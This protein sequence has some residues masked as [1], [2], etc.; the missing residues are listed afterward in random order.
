MKK[1]KVFFFLLLVI[2]I[3]SLPKDVDAAGL[4]NKNYCLS[5]KRYYQV[6]WDPQ[7]STAVTLDKI[8]ETAINNGFV[9]Y[10]PGTTDLTPYK[11]NVVQ[12]ADNCYIDSYGS[13]QT[14]PTTAEDKKYE[15]N[16]VLALNEEG[17]NYKNIIMELNLSNGLINIKIK[18]IFNGT[19]KIR[20]A[21]TEQ[22][23]NL[24]GR[25]ATEL[26]NFLTKEGDYYVLRNV[27]PSTVIC[28][29]NG[30]CSIDTNK[31]YFEY[32]I[33]D[34]SSPCNNT[35]I[36]GIDLVVNTADSVDIDNP[37]LT[38][39]DPSNSYG[40]KTVED[41]IQYLIDNKIIYS[42]DPAYLQTLITTLKQS[43]A[44]ICYQDKITYSQYQTL[45][46]DIQKA[47]QNLQMLAGNAPDDGYS[48]LDTSNG[49]QCNE[50]RHQGYQ[51]VYSQSG[52]YWGITCWEKYDIYP[53]GAKLVYAGA[54]FTYGGTFKA[55]RQCSIVHKQQVIKKPKCVYSCETSC[56]YDER[57]GRKE[58]QS[59]AGPNDDFDACVNSCDGGK[60]TQSC[61]NSC[62]N[63]VYGNSEPRD[64]SILDSKLEKPT[65]FL[66]H[67]IERTAQI[68]GTVTSTAGCNFTGASVDGAGNYKGM[69]SCPV[70]TEHCGDV[71]VT[72]STYCDNH[73]GICH[74]YETVGP[75]G[76]VDNPDELYVQ[77]LRDSVNE[78]NSFEAI[79]EEQ[80]KT[81]SYEINISDSYLKKGNQA[82]TYTVTSGNADIIKNVSHT[83]G[84]VGGN[85]TVQ[86]GNVGN[87][88]ATFCSKN[89]V[90]ITVDLQLPEAYVNKTTGL[91]AYK[92][93]RGYE[94]F[95]T[96]T[97]RLGSINFDAKRFY[98]GDRKYYTDPKSRNTNVSIPINYDDKVSLIGYDQY[99]S[100]DNKKSTITVNVEGIGTK[101]Y[102]DQINCFYGVYN[103]LFIDPDDPTQ[104]DG[105]NCPDCDQPCTGPNCPETC[106][107]PDCPGGDTPPIDYSGITFIYRPIDL[108][109]VF[110][111]DR[112]PRWNWTNGAIPTDSR[113]YNL[114][115]YKINPI[116][117]TEDIEY[118]G[119]EI[120]SD[121]NE[122]DY[123]I[124]LT[125]EQIMRIRQY[126]KN[127]EDFN[128]D[129]YTNYLDYDM[130]CSTIGGREVC[131]SNF[132]DDTGNVTYTSGYNAQSRKQIA[133]CNNAYGGDCDD[134]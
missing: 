66:E 110:P 24:D 30:N 57:S 105:S 72:F 80:Q 108:V 89:E 54:G 133:I 107:G 58:D 71:G 130:S 103:N 61:I 50:E 29:G 23:K 119:N 94:A 96:N 128:G 62:Y 10:P 113:I 83:S 106:T 48:I 44:G 18:D 134:D 91:A 93:G 120:Y 132:L 16:N 115:G 77:Q 45:R 56:S 92:A 9:A 13:V 3:I 79:A 47:Y 102:S 125:T 129:G 127:V 100:Q 68:I 39:R 126:N 124:I 31:I 84:C 2:S 88:T 114:L 118:K 1:S 42:P 35:Y 33:N 6:S 15:L 40:C 4:Q 49:F 8:D 63:T 82:F 41:Y 19:T 112:N 52:T 64:L 34:S 122:V 59:S 26:D 55:T 85:Q 69:Y 81:G 46:E 109:D 37:A 5:D 70:H 131:T 28:D 99:F 101:D 20:Y 7:V 38:S 97:G 121:T 98:A 74:I 25:L 75:A 14:C 86:L 123:D 51:V 67:S 111:N 73:N 78:L 116:E 87:V 12:K 76:C 90:S 21:A 65:S 95:D 22:D 36:A 53:V 11:I 43:Y 17:D 32:Y 27:Q 117:L 60:Y 104:V